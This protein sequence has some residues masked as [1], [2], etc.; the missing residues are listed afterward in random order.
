MKYE[1]IIYG[2][3]ISAKI[4]TSL[5]AK[6]GFKV[7]LITDRN[8]DLSRSKTNLV[9]FLSQGSLDYLSANIPMTTLFDLYPEIRTIDCLLNSINENKFQPIRFN[10]DKK[11]ILG[12][13]IKN[14]ELEKYLDEDIK[15]S[16]NLKIIYSK[17]P[18][19][20][21]NTINGVNLTLQNGECLQSDLFVLSSSH[22]SIAKQLKIKFVSQD[23]LQKALSIN[24][25][26]DIKN[27]NCAFQVFTPDGPLALL[28]YSSE[29]ASVVWSVKHNSQILKKNNDELINI[30]SKHLSDR[31]SS[32]K[33][34]S[35]EKYNL[36]F[37]Y[38]KKLF[39]KNVVLLGNVAHN[40]HPIAGQGLNLSIKDI[41][42]FVE[43]VCKYSSLGYKVNNQSM[44]EEFDT[45]RK[46]DN[47]AYSFG[48][49]TLNGIFSSDNKL[50][51]FT[52][53]QG[54][55]LL[56]NNKRL[57]ELIVN[58]ATGKNFFKKL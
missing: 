55:K 46:L 22:S 25:S 42:L 19:S 51:N 21:Q 53:R 23:L 11:E 18:P 39:Y 36:H 38:A 10:E 48:T 2:S 56:E 52:T 57:K 27:K 14:N 37:I 28:P 16:T 31:V 33:I 15:N 44:L 9:T 20:V 24:I 1:F 7:C 43:K 47:T 45:K 13:I 12:K 40:I 32:P 50:V 6:K 5:L 49:F 26:G 8:P 30:I 34:S 29:Q 41:S 3:G 4:V 58:S 35:I 17:Q 54:L